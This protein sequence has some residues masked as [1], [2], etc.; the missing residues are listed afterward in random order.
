MIILSV[1]LQNISCDTGTILDKE[2]HCD[3]YQGIYVA[4]KIGLVAF[5]SL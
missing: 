4:E 2:Q 1:A 5:T 3:N